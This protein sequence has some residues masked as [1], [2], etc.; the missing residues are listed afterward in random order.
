MHIAKMA[1]VIAIAGTIAVS[2][3]FAQTFPKP[4]LRTSPGTTLPKINEMVFPALD[5]IYG[6]DKFDA[7]GTYDAGQYGP[8]YEKGVTPA[9]A[10]N[11]LPYGHIFGGNTGLRL[12][13]F[14]MDRIE[15]AQLDLPTGNNPIA[16]TLSDPVASNP[17]SCGHIG[18]GKG[19]IELSMVIPEV[20]RVTNAKLYLFGRKEPANNVLLNFDG[21]KLQD[22]PKTGCEV[23]PPV[24]FAE[25]DLIIHPLPRMGTPRSQ[26]FTGTGASV[27]GTLNIPG[28][29]MSEVRL[30]GPNNGVTTLSRPSSGASLVTVNVTS[31]MPA[32]PST[33]TAQIISAVPLLRGATVQPVTVWDTVRNRETIDSEATV[34]RH[35]EF[36]PVYDLTFTRTGARQAPSLKGFDPGNI[37]YVVLPGGTTD[38]EGN[39]YTNLNSPT[40]CEKMDT[41]ISPDKSI[42][43]NRR[44]F[45]LPGIKWGIKNSGSGDATGSFVGELRTGSTS[46]QV[47]STF[48]FSNLAA[49]AT[50]EAPLYTRPKSETTVAILS[51]SPL[52]YHA[53]AETEGINDNAGYFVTVR[54]VSGSGVRLASQ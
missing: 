15:K 25:I 3:A 40:F 6:S 19:S 29:S 24:S 22:C 26:Q 27:T 41:P 53:G 21:S 31:Q 54:G 46:G 9:R 4:T 8:I 10:G 42:I 47:V 36:L 44:T 38:S 51:N 11:S 18:V 50:V 35:R 33:V 37:L 17:A 7:C 32:A 52:C 45:D 20:T 1:G 12:A 39:N 28:S 49:G 14:R 48:N 5:T 23:S 30:I 13:G 2:S 34:Q 43:A 16:V